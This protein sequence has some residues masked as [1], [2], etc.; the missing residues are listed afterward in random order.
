MFKINY[1][2]VDGG[3]EATPEVPA[4][5]PAPAAPAPTPAAPAPSIPTPAAGTYNVGG[6]TITDADIER[7]RGQLAQERQQFDPRQF[8]QMQAA[9]LKEALAPLVPKPQAP[10]KIYESEDFFSDRR[11]FLEGMKQLIQESLNPMQEQFTQKLDP[12]T[13]QMQQ[14]NQLLPLLYARSAENPQFSQITTRATELM[15]KYGLSQMQALNMAQDEVGKQGMR[16]INSPPRSASAPDTR[17]GTLPSDP[18]DL[19]TGPADFRDIISKLPPMS[20]LG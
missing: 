11:V 10:P 17:Q 19:P 12:F 15:Q 16:K 4:E 7:A 8:A 20:T 1:S 3:G 2:A 6:V 14:V 13:Q 18:L 5:A 9:A